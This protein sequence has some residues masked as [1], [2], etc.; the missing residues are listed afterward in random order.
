MT[1]MLSCTKAGRAAVGTR[2]FIQE[3]RNPE[4]Q[5]EEGD[6]LFW[7]MWTGKSGGG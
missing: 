4:F 5:F 7:N 1:E 6:P 2:Q 3:R